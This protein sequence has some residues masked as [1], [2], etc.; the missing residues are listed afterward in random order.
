MSCPS[1]DASVTAVMNNLNTIIQD[2][3]ANISLTELGLSCPTGT[4]NS[5]NCACLSSE[6]SQLSGSGSETSD[7][8]TFIE[9]TY[10]LAIGQINNLM[11]FTIYDY[12]L[13]SKVNDSSSFSYSFNATY[14]T[15]PV[16]NFSVNASETTNLCPVPAITTCGPCC[17]DPFESCF[18]NW[19]CDCTTTPAGW[20]PVTV[21]FSETGSVTINNPIL[22]GD[23]AFSV[24]CDAPPTST[25]SYTTIPITT[26]S[27]SPSGTVY[28]Y[29]MVLSNLNMT[30]STVNVSVSGDLPIQLGIADAPWVQNLMNIYVFPA[31]TT[32]INNYLETIA[33][34]VINT[35]TPSS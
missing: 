19:T 11:D 6:I 28:F 32:A 2:E 13:I 27:S 23:I 5:M 18:Y 14:Y 12:S 29:N 15:S 9:Y 16:A 4:L 25:G 22:S 3:L 33:I 10:A 34:E 26:T 30:F 31:A 20:C 21:Y 35:R 7:G 8:V 17:D 24:S 1:F